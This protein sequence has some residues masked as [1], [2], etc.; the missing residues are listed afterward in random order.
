MR[1]ALFAAVL[2][3]ALA[4]VRWTPLATYLDQ[5][6][7]ARQLERLSD[8]WWSPALLVALYGVLAPL[9]VPATPLVFAGGA[10]F[11]TAWGALWN[12]TGC[13]LGAATSYGFARGLGRGF[14]ARIA[15]GRLK[16]VER[17][18]ARAD[19]W[20]LVAIRFVPLPFPLVNFA[21]ALAGVPPGRFLLSSVVGLTPG[22]AVYTFFGTS[23]LRAF[24]GE[25][26]GAA[27][28]GA[29]S[30]ILLLFLLTFLPRWWIA[31]GRR[32]R[33]HELRA[34]RSGRGGGRG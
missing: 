19:F 6:E 25:G 26:G 5:N 15:R 20:S 16:K 23:L 30:A 17:R 11:G 24:G 9:G 14:V 18:L 22:V 28:L 31:R 12:I 13:L 2:A 27:S 8:P 32:R 29:I 7:L 3:A 1:F 10:V 34:E 33:Y 21:A 4:A